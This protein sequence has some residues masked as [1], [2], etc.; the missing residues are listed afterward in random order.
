MNIKIGDQIY[1]HK[2][3]VRSY[4]TVTRVGDTWVMVNWNDS[5]D[6]NWSHFDKDDLELSYYYFPPGGKRQVFSAA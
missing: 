4:G 3:T 2:D 6:G 5:T 1:T